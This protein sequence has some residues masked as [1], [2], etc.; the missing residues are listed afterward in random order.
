V[1]HNALLKL[2]PY[3]EAPHPVE[4]QALLRMA[5]FND[6]AELL[7]DSRKTY[8]VALY[9]RVSALQAA[10]EAWFKVE[11][12]NGFAPFV[13]A[14]A[15]L[16]SGAVDEELLPL[17]N[18]AIRRDGR[19]WEFPFE[20]AQLHERERDFP[21]AATQY[22]K[23]IA[24]NPKVPEPHYRLARVYDRL[25]KPE[26]AARERKLHQSLQANTKGGMQ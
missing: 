20:L 5:R 15:R 1:S 10:A 14:R 18:E 7:G 25:N 8:G 17:F 19:V 3:D 9:D 12:A 21:A 24:L 4:A 2:L 26:P 16:A 11:T 23:A 13:L 22:E 6:A